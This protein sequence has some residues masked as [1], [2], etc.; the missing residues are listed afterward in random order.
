M[1]LIKDDVLRDTF[2][3]KGLFRANDFH[4]TVI[5]KKYQEKILELLN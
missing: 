1:M 4:A 3:Q 2:A 5:G